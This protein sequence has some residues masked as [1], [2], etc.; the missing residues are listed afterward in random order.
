MQA[1]AGC[2]AAAWIRVRRRDRHGRSSKS[3]TQRG[4]FAPMA[5][6]AARNCRRNRQ[7]STPRLSFDKA[8]VADHGDAI[9]DAM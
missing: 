2:L 1:I 4:F 9:G 5:G 3:S 7:N 6:P 8:L